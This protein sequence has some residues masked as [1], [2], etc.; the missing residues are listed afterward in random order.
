MQTLFLLILNG[1][2]AEGGGFTAFEKRKLSVFI[3]DKGN[4]Y[5]NTTVL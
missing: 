1:W 2:Y 3:A 4:F 5:S